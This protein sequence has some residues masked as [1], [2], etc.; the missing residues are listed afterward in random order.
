MQEKFTLKP[1]KESNE[2]KELKPES[3]EIKPIDPEISEEAKKRAGKSIEDVEN[4]MDENE[5]PTI[6]SEV[7]EPVSFRKK[8]EEE[9]K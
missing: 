9:K 5:E 8:P 7:I 4:A 6:K 3:I 1:K 2:D